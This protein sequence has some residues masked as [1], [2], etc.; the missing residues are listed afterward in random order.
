VLQWCG[1]CKLIYPELVKLSAELAPAATIVKFNCNQNNKELAK[2]LGIKVGSWLRLQEKD[3]YCRSFFCKSQRSFLRAVALHVVVKSGG[4]QVI[5][6]M[7][8][9]N[10]HPI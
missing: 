2:A 8:C 1:P 10:H 7:C 5:R 9:Q 6:D 4:L 3:V